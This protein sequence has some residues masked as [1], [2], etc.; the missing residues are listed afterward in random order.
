MLIVS[1]SFVYVEMGLN[2]STI[3]GQ[4]NAL[5]RWLQALL[6]Q[7]TVTYDPIPDGINFHRK[8]NGRHQCSALHI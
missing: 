5:L 7:N 1:S 8:T 2:E 6:L 4:K 3:P